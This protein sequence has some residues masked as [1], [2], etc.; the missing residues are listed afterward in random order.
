MKLRNCSFGRQHREESRSW[1]AAEVPGNN[2]YLG[3]GCCFW[4]GYWSAQSGGLSTT[5][6]NEE[7]SPIKELPPEFRHKVQELAVTFGAG[8][9][10][11]ARRNS[12]TTG[13]KSRTRKSQ[14]RACGCRL[15]LRPSPSLLTDPT[16]FKFHKF[17]NSPTRV[18]P[19][20][21]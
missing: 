17:T 1:P 8:A 4:R 2:P 6:Y 9:R 15:Q 14:F 19:L 12:G 3:L 13:R 16:R 11:L 20:G 21:A 7:R 18:T 10:S 5:L